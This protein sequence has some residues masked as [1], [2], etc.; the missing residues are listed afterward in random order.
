MRATLRL[1]ASVKPARYLEPFTPTGLTGLNTHPSPRPTLIYLYTSTLEKLKAFP[2]SSAYRQATEALTRHRL[3][4]VESTKP[5]GYEAWLER[6]KKAV[7]AE[8]ER[9]ASLRLADGSYAAIQRDDNSDNP[10]GEEWDGEKLEPTTEGPARTAEQQARW[11][12]EIEEATSS[13]ADAKS[14]FHTKQMKWENEPALDADQIAEIE[15]KIGAGLIEEVIQV[16]E[17]ELKL[18]DEL[19]KSKSWEEL[20]EK[21]RPGQWTYFERKTD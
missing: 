5:A 9:F 10:R 12:K 4:I 2:E 15:K 20:E 13:A 11:E 6:V 18:V 14:D 3:Q 19:Y 16:A 17:G 21:P 7:A 8:P 1:L